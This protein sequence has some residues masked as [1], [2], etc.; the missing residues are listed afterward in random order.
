MITKAAVRSLALVYAFSLFGAPALAEPPPAED[1]GRTGLWIGA[2][3]TYG[4]ENWSIHQDKATDAYGF[5]FLLGYRVSEWVGVEIDIG[6]LNNFTRHSLTT[7]GVVTSMVKAKVY[8]LSG[9]YQPFISLGIGA[10]SGVGD[11]NVENQTDWATKTGLGMEIY[12]TRN[13]AVNAEA[14]YVWTLGDVRDLDYASFGLGFIY[15][16]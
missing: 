1:F 11:S 3:G 12:V 8:P 5:D 9:R 6:Y 10:F 2:Q 15:R 4:L 14:T 16:F 7:Q 13:W